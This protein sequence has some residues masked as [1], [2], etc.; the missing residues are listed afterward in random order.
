LWDLC[1]D[2]WI[3]W[4]SGET[5][6]LSICWHL[7]AFSAQPL[8]RSFMSFERQHEK[9]QLKNAHVNIYKIWVW[10]WS[11]CVELSIRWK[12]LRVLA[13]IHGTE[14]QGFLA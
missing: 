6:L 5:I 3:W 12:W 11:H 10:V 2:P 13:R 9:V 8:Q 14:S 1:N 7:P 4:C